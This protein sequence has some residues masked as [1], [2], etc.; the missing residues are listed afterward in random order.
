MSKKFCQ[1]GVRLDVGKP[2]TFTTEI[3]EVKQ[4]HVIS[5]LFG[6]PL[7]GRRGRAGGGNRLPTDQESP[8]R[9]PP[10]RRGRSAR[11]DPVRRRGF[12]EGAAPRSERGSRPDPDRSR[13]GGAGN[14]VPGA[15]D[16]EANSPER[17]ETRPP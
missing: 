3:S 9:R 15:P 4:P 10:D 6:R 13:E 16:G 1:P 12:P 11:A 2:S 7:R 5:C 14:Q 17:G 8:A